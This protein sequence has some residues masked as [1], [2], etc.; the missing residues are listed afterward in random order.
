M[1]FGAGGI[2]PPKGTMVKACELARTHVEPTGSPAA[3]PCPITRSALVVFG[4]V[5][6]MAGCSTGAPAPP[7]SAPSTRATGRLDPAIIQ[8]VMRAA[9]DDFRSCYHQGLAGDSKLEGR[10]ATRFA[11][12]RDGATSHVDISGSDQRMRDVGVARCVAGV[13]ERL[14][15]PEPNGGTVTVTY[16]IQFS[17]GG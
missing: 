16:P 17:P 1:V 6:V 2:M 12:E 8:R 4:A 5:L 3:A 14:R 7:A 13:I 11:I 9:F 15:F 10:V